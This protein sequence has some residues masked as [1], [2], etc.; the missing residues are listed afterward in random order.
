M[1]KHH[2]PS[3]QPSYDVRQE[4]FQLTH[5]FPRP[6]HWTIQKFFT[7]VSGKPAHDEVPLFGTKIAHVLTLLGM[8][9]GGI[10]LNYWCFVTI[11]HQPLMAVT[12]LAGTWLIAGGC[13][14]FMGTISHQ[15]V[16]GRLF[17]SKPLD[18]TVVELGTSL[19]L[20][21]GFDEAWKRH[22]VEH[23][24]SH[25]LTTLK[26]P[27][28]KALWDLGF[29]P[30]LSPSYYWRLLWLTL[31]NPLFH[32]R[33]F[34]QR[35]RVNFVVAPLS[36]R[37]LVGLLYGGLLTTVSLTHA[38][39][40]FLVVWLLPIT[41]GYHIAD[42]LEQASEHYW[43]VELP[44]E[45][46]A[47]QMQGR[48]TVIRYFG[49]LPPQRSFSDAPQSWL[50]FILSWFVYHLPCR[51]IVPGE[52]DSHWAHHKNPTLDWSTGAFEQRDLLTQDSQSELWGMI[53]SL[54]AVFDSLSQS[55]LHI[56]DD[57]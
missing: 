52:W 24:N 26:D 56:D 21:S 22:I 17:H 35:L 27:Q 5:R 29:Q 23:H 30:G 15:G 13:R 32:W 14:Y 7:L 40:A 33:Q 46:S 16:H 38:F 50:W 9:G 42:L 37:L 55:S 47:Q 57:A 6:L 10:S 41:I 48:K 2:I 11:R 28:A 4:L 51:L 31:L 39:L 20:Q 25:I 34:L 43:F 49:S 8:I 3:S 12:W 45:L 36:R 19:I 53:A 1:L 54:N 18:R 44:P